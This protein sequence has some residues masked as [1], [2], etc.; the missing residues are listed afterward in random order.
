VSDDLCCCDDLG[1]AMAG[2]EATLDL[3][4]LGLVPPFA[5]AE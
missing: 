2:S 3:S 5:I 4:S 1:F